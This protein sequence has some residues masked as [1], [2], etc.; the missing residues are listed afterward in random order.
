MTSEAILKQHLKM[1][2]ERLLVLH[3]YQR[4]IK[5]PYLQSAL[6]LTIEDTQEAI[7]HVSSRLRQLGVVSS[8]QIS[9]DTSEKLLRQSRKRRTLSD[10]I[11]FIWQGLSYQIEWYDL[12]I[13]ELVNDPDSQAILVTLAE[14][15]QTDLERWENLSAEMKVSLDKLV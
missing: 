6:N 10:K 13:K 8:R 5:D 15:A 2:L 1:H 12:Q 7:S 3:K 14:R 11:V 9:E 4:N